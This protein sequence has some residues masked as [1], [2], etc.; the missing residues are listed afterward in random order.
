[1]AIRT[2]AALAAKPKTTPGFAKNPSRG[3]GGVLGPDWRAGI[4]GVQS[5]A[6]C[7]Q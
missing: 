5:L 2:V 4:S 7:Q 6:G 1:M 3:C